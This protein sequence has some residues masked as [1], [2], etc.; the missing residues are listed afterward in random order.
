VYLGEK[1]NE[2]TLKALSADGVLASARVVHF[3]THGLL[4]NQ[5]E[6]LTAA[7]AEPTLL[8]TPPANATEENDGLLTAS[9]IARLKLGAD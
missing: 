2:A 4:A 9:E 3:A 5:A 1:A 7:K 8:L 6:M